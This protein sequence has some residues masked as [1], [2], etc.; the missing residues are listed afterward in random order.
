MDDSMALIPPSPTAE[1]PPATI[2]IP[3]EIEKPL[4]IVIPTNQQ[5]YEYIEAPPSPDHEEK[6]TVVVVP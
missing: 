3:M 5:G 1:E 6:E 4:P 2:V